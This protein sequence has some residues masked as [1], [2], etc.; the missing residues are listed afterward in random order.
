V[1]QVLTRGALE[2]ALRIEPAALRE[3]Q[4]EFLRAAVADAGREGVGAER[5]L[6][7]LMPDRDSNPRHLE[8]APGLADELGIRSK[9]IGVPYEQL[10]LILVAL[11][12]GWAVADIARALATDEERVRYVL[13]LL[14]GAERMRR[15]RVPEAPRPQAREARP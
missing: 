11:S 9:L 3:Q 8:D 13:R 12:R 14:E 6:A 2:A 15:V 10:D 7:L 4:V 5:T 1:S